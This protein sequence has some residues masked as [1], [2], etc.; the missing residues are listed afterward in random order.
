[1]QL[2]QVVA[3]AGA[4]GAL[5]LA[6]TPAD[7]YV[8]GFSFGGSGNVVLKLDDAALIE[9]VDSGWYDDAG[10]H[11]PTNDNYYVGAAS[12]PTPGAA[13]RDLNN[14][15]VFD[16]SNL[17]GTF[18]S[19]SLVINS[20]QVSR[21]ETYELFDYTGDI[22]DL[23]DGSAAGAHADLESGAGYG[24]FAYTSGDAYTL[25]ELALSGAA[26]ADINAAVG[27]RFAF[28]GSVGAASSLVPEPAT[29]AMMLL[30]FAGLGGALRARRR[31][32]VVG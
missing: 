10:S 14:F 16:L 3:A 18:N 23:L 29:W 11:T 22:D 13:G 9:A 17:R 19:A 20:F 12:D 8:F 30:G 1:M 15:F 6:A 27:G 2:F 31:M 24:A 26:L 21:S 7:A 5:A 4:A 28:G 32:T 25:R